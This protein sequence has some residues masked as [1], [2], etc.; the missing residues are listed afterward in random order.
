MSDSLIANGIYPGMSRSDALEND[1]LYR[2]K[3]A[4]PAPELRREENTKIAAGIPLEPGEWISTSYDA[5]GR[6]I[7][8]A[9][10]GRG[11]VKP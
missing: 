6:A 2:E 7:S 8:S 10:M 4:P 3:M 9:Y 1:T 11:L 5:D